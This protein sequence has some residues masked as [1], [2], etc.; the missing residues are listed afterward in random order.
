[1]SVLKLLPHVRI[2][3]G[4]SY[5]R[6]MFYH[7][8]R[9][10][11]AINFTVQGMS[12]DDFTSMYFVFKVKREDAEEVFMMALKNG[13]IKP[14]MEFR[15]RMRYVLADDALKDLISDLN[16]FHRL[17][18]EFCYQKWNSICTPTEEEQEGRKIFYSDK[19]LCERFFNRAEINRSNFKKVQ[20][21]NDNLK[22]KY[23]KCIKEK[24]EKTIKEY[25]FLLDPIFKIV[26]P[27][28]LESSGN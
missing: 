14:I 25:A 6:N 2:V 4:T 19:K 11:P 23:F 27:P 26:F 24:Y 28:L 3:E 22:N 12:I 21:T 20:K 17:E 18:D 1:M 10:Y 16:S 5:R 13:L 9:E 15:N 8:C 7:F